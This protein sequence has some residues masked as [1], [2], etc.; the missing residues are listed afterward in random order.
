MD[1]PYA[2]NLV[3]GK[4]R[5]TKGHEWEGA[6]IGAPFSISFSTPTGEKK[7]AGLCLVCLYAF[8]DV[9]LKDIGRVSV[10]SDDKRGSDES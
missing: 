5:C 7:I 9:L 1:N 3:Q 6:Y 10:V 2:L 8:A 4:Y